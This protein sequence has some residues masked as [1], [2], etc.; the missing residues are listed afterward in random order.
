MKKRSKIKEVR[1]EI[2]ESEGEEMLDIRNYY[3]N[4][5]TTPYESVKSIIRR[6]RLSSKRG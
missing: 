2:M 1:R 6:N 5:D 3:G 4:K